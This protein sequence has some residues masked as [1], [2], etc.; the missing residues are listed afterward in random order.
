MVEEEK[1]IE[2]IVEERT[3]DKEKLFRVIG[4]IFSLVVIIVLI[5]IK[6]NKP[7]FPLFW[8]IG[9]II[10]IIIF[11]FAMFFGFTLY[12]KYQ[13]AMAKK[14]LEGK[15]PP[16]ITL[17]QADQLIKQLLVKPNYS[18]YAVG[19]LQHRVYV[20]GEHTK[21]RVLLVHLSPTPY[22]SAPYQFIIMNLHYP[23]ELY[24]YIT[25]KKYNPGE[26]TKMVNALSCD[27]KDEPDYERRVET[28]LSSGKQIEYVKKSQ[29][30]KDDKSKEKKEDLE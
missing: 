29:K 26:L 11:F 3:K 25:Q 8:F 15:L 13:E 21:S 6:V 5:I 16:A 1:Q 17:E 12:R 18:D 22:S 9:G 24:S 20:V 7:E 27:P 23:K 10:L 28:D 4:T 30:Q 2:E 14:N 19:W